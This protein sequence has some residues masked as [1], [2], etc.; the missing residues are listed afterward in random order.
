MKRPTAAYLLPVVI[1]LAAVFVLGR[2]LSQQPPPRRGGS[3]Q[4]SDHPATW[5]Q[6]DAR[7]VLNSWTYPGIQN[8]SMSGAQGFRGATREFDVKALPVRVW[9]FYSQKAGYISAKHW[10]QPPSGMCSASAN[11]LGS[12]NI[13]VDQAQPQF[14]TSTFFLTTTQYVVSAMVVL[15]KA[16]GT[17]HVILH[18]G[19]PGPNQGSALNGV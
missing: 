4:T 10:T 7:A 18:V 2:I 3:L 16:N 13:I 5:S 14:Q 12:A 1:V 15:S 19:K 9:E 17:S 6:A 8:S 11:S